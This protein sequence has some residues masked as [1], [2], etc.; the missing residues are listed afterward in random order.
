MH[1][2]YVCVCIHIYIYISNLY[3]IILPVTRRIYTKCYRSILHSIILCY[4]VF[5]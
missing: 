3:N 4:V 2:I 5:I 1:N